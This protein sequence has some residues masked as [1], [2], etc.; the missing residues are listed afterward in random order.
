MVKIL[1]PRIETPTPATLA[2][3]TGCGI[4]ETMLSEQVQRLAVATIVGAG[5]WAFGLVMDGLVREEDA[6]EASTN[7]H[8]FSLA[9][10]S[11]RLGE[12]ARQAKE[13]ARQAA[14]PPRPHT[15]PPPAETP[16]EA[17]FRPA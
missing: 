13:A 17:T 16:A 12:D 4:P 6:S 15:P 14:A 3:Q 7:P 2:H 8:D 11:A 10:K 9:L 5:L 1:A